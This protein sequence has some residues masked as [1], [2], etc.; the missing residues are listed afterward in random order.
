MKTSY[1]L[2]IVCIMLA[3]SIIPL[4]ATGYDRGSDPSEIPARASVGYPLEQGSR[5]YVHDQVKTLNDSY[6]LPIP[7]GSKVLS[8]DISVAPIPHSVD[9]TKY[10]LDPWIRVGTK[11]NDMDFPSLTGSDPSYHLGTWGRQT[12]GSLGQSFAV[13][14]S[15]TPFVFE[16]ILPEGTEINHM[17]LD[18]QGYQ[19][20]DKV[21]T[22][23]VEG[24]SRGD[25]MGAALINAGR[26]KTSTADTLITGATDG[27]L[28]YGILYRIHYSSGS[29]LKEVMANGP[30]ESADYSSSIS[31]KFKVTSSIEYIAV[32][33]PGGGKD[34]HGAVHLYNVR[35]SYGTNTEDT[36][37][38]NTT[39]ESFG[40]SV[41][42]GDIDDD[43]WKEII[44]GA[45]DANSGS[46]K[47]YI[48]KYDTA[49]PDFSDKT[50][51][52]AVI[53]SPSVSKFG[54]IVSCGDMNDDGIDDIAIASEDGVHIYFGSS[55]FDTVKDLE[56][57]PVGDASLSDFSF[58]GFIGDTLGSGS[59]T[60]AIGAPANTD[61]KVLLYDASDPPDAVLDATITGSGIRNFGTYVS[62]SYD[63]D[64]DG[65]PD[66]AIGAPDF[67]TGSQVVIRSR[68]L[69]QKDIFYD[70]RDGSMFGT[71]VVLGADLRGDGYAD[72]CSG[73]VFKDGI[74]S[75]GSGR[76]IINEYYDVSTLPSN[77]PSIW[78][79]GEKV[80]EYGDDHLTEKVNTG[81]MSD[82]VSDLV[83]GLATDPDLSTQFH[84][85]VRV[86]IRISC[87][88][89]DPIEWSTRFNISSLDIRYDH[90]VELTDISEKINDEIKTM[91]VQ[92][93]GY[94]HVPFRFFSKAPGGLMIERLEMDIDM[95]PVFSGYPNRLYI[96]EDTCDPRIMDLHAY[97]SD[98]RTPIQNL[99]I[100][101]FPGLINT[102]YVN[103]S[104]VEGRYLKADAFNDT[105]PTISNDNWT[106]SVYPLIRITDHTGLQV[107]ISDIIIEV[108]PVNDAP[109]LKTL[110]QTDIL[111]DTRW[112][113]TPTFY[114]AEGDNATF[115]YSDLP[116]MFLQNN[117]TLVWDVNNSHVGE[118]PLFITVTDGMDSRTYRFV[119]TVINKNDPPFFISLPPE[120]IEVYVGDIYEFNIT[121]EDIDP[122]D[123]L[124][125]LLVEGESAVLDRYTGE[126]TFTASRFY[127]DPIRFKISVMDRDESEITYSFL[128]RVLQRFLPPEVRP[129]RNTDLFDMVPWN[130]E[131]I[132]TDPQGDVPSISLYA[133]PS[134]MQFDSFRNLLTWTPEVDQVGEHN[135]SIQVNSSGFSIL[136][137]FTL[138][139]LR[140]VRSW[141][142][143]LSSPEYGE[144]VVGT[145]KITGVV[146][147]EPGH[148]RLVQLKARDGSWV[149]TTLLENTFNF[150]V[151]TNRYK[152]GERVFE[153][154]AF[155]GYEYHEFSTSIVIANHEGEW[156]VWAYFLLAL[157]TVLVLAGLGY[158]GYLGYGFYRKKEEERLRQEKLADILKSKQDMEEFLVQNIS[159][160]SLDDF[161]IKPNEAEAMDL[162]DLIRRTD[163]EIKV[164]EKV[165]TMSISKG[166]FQLSEEISPHGEGDAPATLDEDTST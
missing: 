91:Q 63:V 111:Q 132:V 86:P 108:T 94:H 103:F 139:V 2:M 155:D 7:K 57:D 50:R 36:L 26:I 9:P 113:Y 16:T 150:D 143:M 123:R 44:V 60:L 6:Y 28:N 75:E 127:P 148:A 93:D 149:N 72:I 25:R 95:P 13:F 135:V 62:A 165:A 110:P 77:T 100:E 164:E 68:S 99:M 90:T 85:Y 144:K 46:G 32:G 65:D 146:L 37:Y 97:L 105:S 160:P 56:I 104:I 126:F 117:R 98:D 73:A 118:H 41:A 47:V 55:S 151:D 153:M 133:G 67:S 48:L 107:T 89:S 8:T 119:L 88:T 45:P 29:F 5:L 43:G 161:P 152:D 120:Y 162:D 61:R 145:L 64:G 96:K 83:H 33:A 122:D 154:R 81:D 147:V 158:A 11:N 59:D 79:G 19:R 106:G 80:W 34:Q 166:V 124:E 30:D 14:D 141:N 35:N 69:G 130:H 115:T 24:D 54:R 121:A 82:T 125:Y 22:H 40:A 53:G 12:R 129:V 58:M 71:S 157:M 128:I 134:G 51:L 156:P 131:V 87:A 38:G 17:S 10:P 39:L 66:F 31:Q 114:D 78:I 1:S 74:V 101:V 76:V 27:S 23:E 163:S 116:G 102:S 20:S 52:K 4:Q 84:K 142:V 3:V 15:P 138:S 112:I 42:V 92:Q 159:S 136:Y 70:S 21:V 18:L 140:S 109:A 137:N 49:N